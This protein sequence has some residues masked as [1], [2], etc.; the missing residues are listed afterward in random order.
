MKKAT[1]R[2]RKWRERKKAEGK[3]SF[4]V[5]L[6]TEAQK[7]LVSEKDKTGSSYSAV[8]EKAL[9]SLK[10]PIYK[11]PTA[12]YLS[13]EV[14]EKK[15]TESITSNDKYI[16]KNRIIIDDLA[17]TSEELTEQPGHDKGAYPFNLK[18]DDNFIGRILRLSRNKLSRKKSG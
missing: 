11:Q 6:S 13:V 18:S 3:K 17:Y 4:T 5:V 8:I 12:K 16:N 10:K 14:F 2:I 15:V 9:L 1:E 7:V